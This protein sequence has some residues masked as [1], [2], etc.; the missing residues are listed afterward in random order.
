MSEKLNEKMPR[1]LQELKVKEAMRNFRKRSYEKFFLNYRERV[2]DVI[3]EIFAMYKA[4]AAEEEM[5]AAAEA[6]AS[7]ARGLYNSTGR[8]SK[9]AR[10]MDMQCMTVFY[11]FPAI[12]ECRYGEEDQK[13][14]DRM[15][16][17]WKEAFPDSQISSGTFEEIYGGFKNTIF[18]IPFGKKK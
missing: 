15:I 13:F 3:E 6:Y 11:V 4:G 8:F 9:N 5:D 10:L 16:V 2:S 14:V 18:G 17:K 1:L 7:Y 12:L